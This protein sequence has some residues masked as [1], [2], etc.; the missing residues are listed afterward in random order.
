MRSQSFTSVSRNH[1]LLVYGNDGST[2]GLL[3]ANIFPGCTCLSVNIC[4]RTPPF[5]TII[6]I[7]QYIMLSRDIPR[8]L[9][10][11]LFNIEKE[12]LA[13]LFQLEHG[14]DSPSM[15]GERFIV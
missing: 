10:T 9:T 8:R 5:G 3:H 7:D 6:T 13:L 12:E 1:D 4:T 15:I 2:R 14:L 11:H